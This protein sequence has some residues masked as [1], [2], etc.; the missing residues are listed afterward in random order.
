MNDTTKKLLDEFLK[1]SENE[2]ILQRFLKSFL[3]TQHIV[4][5]SGEHYIGIQFICNGLTSIS[6]VKSP[7]KFNKKFYY[8]NELFSE[9]NIRQDFE[10]DF[11]SSFDL[12]NELKSKGYEILETI[13]V[14]DVKDDKYW[15]NAVNQ[16]KF[17]QYQ[18]ID[19]YIKSFGPVDVM[20]AFRTT[21]FVKDYIKEHYE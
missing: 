8:D 6:I 15:I 21:E 18:D 4:E 20:Y 3:P 17:Y 14:V 1:N 13:S 2:E 9:F 7:K 11:K 19:E 12:K 10:Y 5:E 16:M